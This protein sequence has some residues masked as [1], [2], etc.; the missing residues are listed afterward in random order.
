MISIDNE[1]ILYDGNLK[2]HRIKL[3]DKIEFLSSNNIQDLIDESIVIAT[4]MGYDIKF[5]D[6]ELGRDNETVAVMFRSI[7]NKFDLCFILNSILVLE[8]CYINIT[9]EVIDL[10]GVEHADLILEKVKNAI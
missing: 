1:G 4:L 5:Y 7:T 8:K 3:N 6:M 10:K 2:L 9:G